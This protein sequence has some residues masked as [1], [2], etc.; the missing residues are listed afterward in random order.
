MEEDPASTAEG[1]TT[2]PAE[3]LASAFPDVDEAT[4]RLTPLTG[5]TEDR[6]LADENPASTTEGDTIAP[7]SWATGADHYCRGGTHLRRC[8]YYKGR[9][10][11]YG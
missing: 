2:A 9:H 7:M 3:V 8:C 1:D 11:R 5:A 10:H 4:R 6:T